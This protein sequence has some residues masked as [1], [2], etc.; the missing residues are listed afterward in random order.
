MPPN[1]TIA[2]CYSGALVPLSGVTNTAL[3][4]PRLE[5]EGFRP[6]PMGTLIEALHQ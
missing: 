2:S 3:N 1:S 6:A 4:N 5:G